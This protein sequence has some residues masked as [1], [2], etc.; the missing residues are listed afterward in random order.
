[1]LKRTSITYLNLTGTMFQDYDK[2]SLLFFD[3]ETTGLSPR[4]SYLYLIGAITWQNGA[5]VC[6]QWFAENYNEE[7]ELLKT[8]LSFSA[9]F[10]QII[11]FNGDRF[12]IPYLKEKCHTYHLTDT[13]STII[14]RDLF[15]MIRPL[16]KLLQLDSLK[17]K[18][19]EQFLGNYREDPFTGGELIQV[20]QEY[21][22]TP[23][24]S[25]LQCLLLHNY[26]DL[27]GMMSIL[28]MLS[29]HL[30][31]S[32]SFQIANSEVNGDCLLV[33]A[34]LP[35]TLPKAFT[36]TEKEVTLF[37][38]KDHISFQIEGIRDT[39]KYFF[40]DYK[41]YYYLPM[42]DIAIHKSL[43]S[44]VDKDHRVPAKIST[45]YNKK[46]GFYLPQ[47][48][49]LFKPV[50]KKD[51]ADKQMYFSCSEAFVQDRERVQMYLQS[52][53]SEL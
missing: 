11:H 32:G 42:E 2:S 18:S 46:K 38:E 52:I 24:D 13:L 4:S 16:K 49:E 17:Q 51:Y 31:L 10:K 34:W 23:S 3:I 36:Y 12:D 50:F 48:E 43:A 21:L 8:F 1:M 22:E 9:P 33:H 29:Y 47:S 41:N 25:R 28:P 37:G 6:T 15:R 44:F 26:E 45:C 14:S 5:W 30:I 39:L 53:V 40:P 35:L 27:L 20:Y 19:L 7:P